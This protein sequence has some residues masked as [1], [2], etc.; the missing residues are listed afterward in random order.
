MSCWDSILASWSLSSISSMGCISLLD[1]K[2]VVVWQTK[3]A[4]VNVALKPG[5]LLA[6]LVPS[7]QQARFSLAQYAQPSENMFSED[8]QA[9]AELKTKLKYAQRLNKNLAT[10]STMIRLKSC[11]RKLS[12]G[13][14]QLVS[15]V[16]CLVFSIHSTSA[17]A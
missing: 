8:Q 7:F 6:R 1:G 3:L 10:I 11:S 17:Q 5:K 15:R 2:E 13:Q 9:V 16:G 4:K 14:A 12:E